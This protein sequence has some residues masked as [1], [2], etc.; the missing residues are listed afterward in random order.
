M[1]LKKETVLYVLLCFLRCRSLSPVEENR[2]QI[3]QFVF[4]LSVLLFNK[5][6]KTWKTFNVIHAMY[7]FAMH[8]FP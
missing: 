4:S 3:I 6:Q 1:K 7:I 2:E 5:H 8:I